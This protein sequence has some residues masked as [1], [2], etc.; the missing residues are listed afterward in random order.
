LQNLILFKSTH[1]YNEKD[2]K[3]HFIYIYNTVLFILRAVFI[4]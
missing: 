2:A 3:T 1:D 4:Y